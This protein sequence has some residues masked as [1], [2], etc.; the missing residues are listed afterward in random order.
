M[1]KNFQDDK[2][3]THA[4]GLSSLKRRMK[5]KKISEMK[6]L[7]NVLHYTQSHLNAIVKDKLSLLVGDIFYYVSHKTA[8]LRRFLSE[9]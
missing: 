8:K 3:W 7:S 9:Q 4:T 6:Y 2:H 5:M 1:K